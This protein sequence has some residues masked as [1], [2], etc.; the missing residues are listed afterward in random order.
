MRQVDCESCGTRIGIETCAECGRGFAL[1]AAHAEGRPREFEDGPLQDSSQVLPV[2]L[3]DFCAA[4]ERRERAGTI[5]EAG[6]RQNT[7]P[8]CHTAAIGLPR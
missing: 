6:M 2:E 8:A 4:K 3:C 7:C 5:V 1:T